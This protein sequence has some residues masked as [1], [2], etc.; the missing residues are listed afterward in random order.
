MASATFEATQEILFT[1]CLVKIQ[2]SE[3]I[4]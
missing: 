4:S 2:P 1:G 3:P